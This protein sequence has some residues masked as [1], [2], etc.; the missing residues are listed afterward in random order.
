MKTKKLLSAD[1]DGTLMFRREG[2]PYFKQTDVQAL[3]AFRQ[4]GNL[5]VINSGRALS[6][7]LPPLEGQID[8]DYLI[9]VSG[10][11]IMDRERRIVYG[12]ELPF[13]LV[14]KVLREHP[15]DVE[16]TFITADNIYALQ[17][18]KPHS[19]PV[20]TLHSSEELDDLKEK[21]LY[22]MSVHFETPQQ[23]EAFRHSLCRDGQEE[24][25]VFVNTK[26]VDLVKKGCSKGVALHWLRDHLDLDTDNIYAIGDAANDIDMLKAAAHPFTFH[27]SEERVKQYCQ[28]CVS[29]VEELLGQMEQ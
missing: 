4:E 10:A 24:L 7:L 8:W 28:G 9:A 15:T 6:W 2:K 1:L 18:K 11:C 17:Q 29:S 23:A 20:Q 13:S 12:Q 26:D 19:L 14:Q 16:I 21:P 3:R 5:L 22:G 25:E 27:Q